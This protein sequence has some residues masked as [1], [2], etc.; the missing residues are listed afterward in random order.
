[1]STTWS[2]NSRKWRKTRTNRSPP[3]TEKTESIC[4]MSRLSERRRSKRSLR[5]LSGTAKIKRSPRGR[6]LRR[7]SASWWRKTL[8][9][10]ARTA[11]M[12]GW[13]SSMLKTKRLPTTSRDS[14]KRSDDLWKPARLTEYLMVSEATSRKASWKVSWILQNTR[15]CS[16]IW[17]RGTLAS[18]RRSNPRERTTCALWSALR[19][20][21][22][23]SCRPRSSTVT[24]KRRRGTPT[25]M[26]KKCQ[27]WQ[28]P[29]LIELTTWAPITCSTRIRL[30][31]QMNIY[32]RKKITH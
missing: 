2:L 11:T 29:C 27:K 24:P 14:S 19:D 30:A 8:S 28:A 16:R 17:A 4:L 13:T 25:L 20:P 31:I 32:N 6:C 7:Q 9:Q 21:I 10:I 5:D 1:M 3:T 12:T 23:R 22:T 26:L 18:S 15:S